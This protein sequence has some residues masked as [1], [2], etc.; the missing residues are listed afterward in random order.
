MK[1]I[2]IFMLVFF[3]SVSLTFAQT[4]WDFDKSHTTIGFS[5]THLIIAEVDGNFKSFNGS[6][7]TNDNNFENA[8]VKFSADVNSINTQN[9]KRDRHLKSDDFF[10]AKKFP[11][12]TFKSKSFNKVDDKNYKMVGNLTIRGITKEITLDVKLNGIIKD[13]WGNT[14]AGFKITGEI[15]RF[16]YGLKWNKLMEAGGAVVSKTVDIVI[17]AE[18][19]KQA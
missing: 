1:L 10:N 7:T 18:L 6:V 17:N 12:V 2:K 9:D 11:Q 4:K 8:Q 5:V 15:N 19:K 13:P 16:D 14:R 3:S